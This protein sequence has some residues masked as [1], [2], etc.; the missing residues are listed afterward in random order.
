MLKGLPWPL[1]DSPDTPD[2]SV[3]KRLNRR[4]SFAGW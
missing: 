1:A 2:S 3:S 4:N